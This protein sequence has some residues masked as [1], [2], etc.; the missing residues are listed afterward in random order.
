M[1]FHTWVFFVFFL[2]VYPVYLL[3]RTNNRLMNIWLML[4]VIYLYLPTVIFVA[5]VNGTGKT[6]TVGK[7][8]FHIRELGLS[9]LLAAG[10]TFRA[11]AI[12]LGDRQ[13]PRYHQAHG[14]R[15]CALRGPQARR[16]QPGRGQRAGCAAAHYRAQSRARLA[17]AALTEFRTCY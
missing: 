8:A 10:D 15:T 1:L 16:R 3:V 4:A 6:T 11:A 13:D 17:S 9:V 2:I 7:L 14:R 12:G 5:G